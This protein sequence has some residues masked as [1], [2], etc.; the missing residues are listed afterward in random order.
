[1]WTQFDP[2]IKE[3]TEACYTLP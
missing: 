3:T 2:Y 1:M